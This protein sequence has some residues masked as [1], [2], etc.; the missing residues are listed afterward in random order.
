MTSTST[1][2]HCK[3]LESARTSPPVIKA[4]IAPPDYSCYLS[5]GDGLAFV[6]HQPVVDKPYLIDDIFKP[7]SFEVQ[8]TK[9]NSTLP[10]TIIVNVY[11]SRAVFLDNSPNSSGSLAPIRTPD[12]YYALIGTVL[13][14]K[15]KTSTTISRMCSTR[16]DWLKTS[17]HQREGTLF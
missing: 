12:F 14:R 11:S 4:D 2:S 10:S 9:T 15:Q 7:S 5:R 16:L 8:P 3:K 17:T 1:S 6:H 13:E